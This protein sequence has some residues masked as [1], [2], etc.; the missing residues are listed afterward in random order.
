MRNVLEIS[1]EPPRKL[2]QTDV[3]FHFE[4]HVAK[5]TTPI[6]Y[7]SVGKN[8]SVT[9]EKPSCATGSSIK[10]CVKNDLEKSKCKSNLY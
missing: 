8:Y 7:L 10:F 2:N 3:I 4:T 6:S 1:N 9:I 5:L